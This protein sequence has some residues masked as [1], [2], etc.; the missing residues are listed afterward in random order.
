[1]AIRGY[2]PEPLPTVLDGGAIVAI[3]AATL[4][5]CGIVSLVLAARTERKD[6]KLYNVMDNTRR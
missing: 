3:V 1:M 5:L 6:V 2:P 4:V